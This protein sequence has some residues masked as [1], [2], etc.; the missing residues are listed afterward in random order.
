MMRRT[1][2]TLEPELQQ[3]A[4]RRAQALGVS[5]SEYLRRL[6]ERDLGGSVKESSASSIFD[7][8]DSGGSDIAGHK[9]VMVGEAVVARSTRPKE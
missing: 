2:I 3:R 5:F 4:R 6:L 8:G 1:Q 7:L 9:D